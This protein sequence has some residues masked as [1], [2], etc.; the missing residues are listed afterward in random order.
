MSEKK[1][2]NKGVVIALLVVVGLLFWG[3]SSNSNRPADYCSNMD[4][5]T[6]AC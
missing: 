2:D 1:N 5:Q 6:G 3:I 4:F